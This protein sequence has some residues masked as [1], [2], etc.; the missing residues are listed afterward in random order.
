[1]AIQVEKI[2]ALQ[3]DQLLS[4]QESHF[5]D[6]KAID[7][8]PA[9]LTE[10]LSAFANSDGGELYIGIE[11]DK[12]GRTFSWRGFQNLEA[13]NGHLQCFEELFPLGQDFQYAFLACEE[14]S[15]FV[16]Q[17]LIQ[18]T[19]EIK[20][21]SDGHPYVRRGAQK[22]KVAGVEAIKRLELSKGITSFETETIAIDLALVTDSYKIVEFI[23]YLIPSVQPESWLRKQQLLRNDK[24]TVAAVLLFADEPQ[25][26][27][28]KR[29][30]IKIYRYKTKDRQGSRETL[31]F[32]PLTIEGPLY[33][34]IQSAVDTVSRKVEET[35]KLGESSLE[36]IEYPPEAVHEIITNAVLHR[37][38]SITDDIHI[39][40]FDN[41][42]EVESPGRL[43][44]HITV[45]NILNERFARNGALVRLLNKFPNPPN[46]DVGEGLNTAFA[47]MTKLGLKE[48]VIEE[49]DN[50]VL[51]SIKHEP[52]ASPEE[53][54]LD[55]L[56]THSTI[57]NKIAREIC[58]IHA[59]YVVKE[60]FNKLAVRGLIQ[61]VPGTRTS[62]TAYEKGPNFANRHKRE[63]I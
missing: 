20:R 62:S 43:P 36:K 10:F 60:I 37:D 18:K 16:L 59:D 58:H 33:D 32:D 21:A 46:K 5:L 8:R 34:Q 39:R 53:V 6:F 45:R 3:H 31:Q 23:L 15:G 14:R 9:R 38:Y 55:Y 24:A 44:G 50:S 51:V 56:E 1:M 42:I 41:R 40:I 35:K 27:L 25:A 29:C 54:I 22:L 4:Q 28:P 17:I 13:A 30:G 26:I 19:R 47:A 57:R 7:V 11:E 49:K 61:R 12:A 48:P 63:K 2:T 52:L